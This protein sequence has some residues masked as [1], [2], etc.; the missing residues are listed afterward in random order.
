MLILATRYNV[1][2]VPGLNRKRITKNA[3]IK[4]AIVA[5]RPLL[6]HFNSSDDFSR[7]VVHLTT[8]VVTK[9]N[10]AVFFAIVHH[11]VRLPQKLV[12]IRHYFFSLLTFRS[13]WYTIY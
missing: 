2:S 6:S 10:L 7:S 5:P 9:M 4:V 8:K 1:I 13:I 3:Q 12:C 11:T